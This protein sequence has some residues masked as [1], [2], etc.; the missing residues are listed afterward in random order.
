MAGGGFVGDEECWVGLVGCA[1]Q[2][3]AVAVVVPPGICRR[4]GAL[5]G[6]GAEGV[7]VGVQVGEGGEVRDAFKPCVMWSGL[8]LGSDQ[9][10]VVC[11]WQCGASC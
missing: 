2:V 5:V 1:E 10:H 9:P 3:V 6:L 4:V 11:C 7:E 8:V